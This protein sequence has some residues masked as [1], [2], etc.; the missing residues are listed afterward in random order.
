[1]RYVVYNELQLTNKIIKTTD[2]SERLFN[3]QRVREHIQP[4]QVN[5]STVRSHWVR[6]NRNKSW[7][8]QKVT[9]SPWQKIWVGN[10][11]GYE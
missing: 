8:V 7:T 4:I 5:Y 3:K 9:W 10:N 6:R 1:M 11:T 2:G